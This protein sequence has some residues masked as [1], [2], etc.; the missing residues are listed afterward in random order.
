MNKTPPINRKKK[1]QKNKRRGTSLECK[2]R[3]ETQKLKE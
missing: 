3:N 2:Q 1:K